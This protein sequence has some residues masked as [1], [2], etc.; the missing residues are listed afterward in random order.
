MH[1][2]YYRR[3]LP[4]WQ[5]AGATFFV[6]FRLAGSIPLE[7]L[8]EFDYLHRFK[9]HQIR[10][11]RNLDPEKMAA[12]LTAEHK[13]HFARVDDW[14]DKNLNGPHF[15]SVPE[16]ATLVAATIR[17]CFVKRPEDWPWTF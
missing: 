8:R 11:N 14:M 12:Y 16:V 13:R 10:Q 1:T 7:K 17:S 4:H 2:D 9:Q 6:T 3:K 15:L 5:P